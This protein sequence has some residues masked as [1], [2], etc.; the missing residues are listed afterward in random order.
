MTS[1]P[2]VETRQQARAGDFVFAPRAAGSFGRGAMPLGMI[3]DE[4]PSGI[5]IVKPYRAN[6]LNY[7][8]D[9]VT[10]T[11]SLQL[12]CASASID[13]GQVRSTR[14][15]NGQAL[16]GFTED[17]GGA[18]EVG[19]CTSDFLQVIALDPVRRDQFLRDPA[20][21]GT[22]VQQPVITDQATQVPSAQRQPF[23]GVSLRGCPGLVLLVSKT[24]DQGMLATPDGAAPLYSLL[25]MASFKRD[26]FDKYNQFGVIPLALRVSARFSSLNLEDITDW[27]FRD[28]AAISS[29]TPFQL[30]PPGDPRLV[31]PA[32][33]RAPG[34]KDAPGGFGQAP[35]DAFSAIASVVSTGEV[36]REPYAG[37]ALPL[38]ISG[39]TTVQNAIAG[40]TDLGA[41]VKLLE[42]IEKRR[43]AEVAGEQVERQVVYGRLVPF[44]VT[45]GRPVTA[46]ELK[47][48]DP[49]RLR[50][51][52]DDLRKISDKNVLED[53]TG[54]VIPD[55]R[56]RL[57]PELVID[58]ELAQG[59]PNRTDRDRIII[60]DK[61]KKKT[62]EEEEEEEDK[63][64]DKDDDKDDKDDK[65]R[66]PKGP[67]DQAGDKNKKG[68]G[69][70]QQRSPSGG[71]VEA[72]R[73]AGGGTIPP[74]G[75]GPVSL[76]GLVGGVVGL[77][78]LAPAPRGI[79]VEAG[80][81]PEAFPDFG[82]GKSACPK[83]PK[84]SSG[85]M[86]LAG[87][88][89]ADD[90]IEVADDL[91]LGEEVLI[92]ETE[93]A[94][95]INQ[96]TPELA[97][98]LSRNRPDKKCPAVDD[99]APKPIDELDQIDPETGKPIDGSAAESALPFGIP[100]GE[101]VAASYEPGT[102]TYRGLGET[103]GV[104]YELGGWQGDERTA[105][106]KDSKGRYTGIEVP[107]PG[108]K[109]QPSA[110]ASLLNMLKPEGTRTTP[111]QGEMGAPASLRGH[112]D[113]V[114]REVQEVRDIVDAAF[115]GD[116]HS[117]YAGNVVVLHTN[118]PLDDAG[119]GQGVAENYIGNHYV[120]PRTEDPEDSTPA[121]LIVM[122]AVEGHRR[123]VVINRAGFRAQRNLSGSVT[124]KGD[125]AGR[126]VI[127]AEKLLT[128]GAT[129]SSPW[130][131]AWIDE[132]IPAPVALTNS[133]A[134]AQQSIAHVPVNERI[135]G[136]AYFFNRGNRP[137]FQTAAP[138]PR[139]MDL[140]AFQGFDGINVSDYAEGFTS[141][142]VDEDG[143]VIVSSEAEQ[144]RLGYP[145][146]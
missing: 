129:D 17:Y 47:D 90:S 137:F 38:G 15:T 50:P 80:V 41:F 32:L 99:R 44:D 74:T 101:V 85:G 124:V 134:L 136:A 140:A 25:T 135:P 72:N 92:S 120:D 96:D 23:F 24:I 106:L 97:E 105:V 98:G 123:S 138:N 9:D 116:R 40:P 115:V 95:I 93:L 39:I 55:S 122:Q 103:F 143:N 52:T 2:E 111:L 68:G 82:G 6:Q 88:P 64:G 125:G 100:L 73:Q 37:T 28:R 112:L 67:G 144:A 62:E 145:S 127:A 14:I 69:S 139:I 66:P 65:D 1:I 22:Q 56:I 8:P 53:D 114:Q 128:D 57:V 132:L 20:E 121:G 119:D 113:A 58:L 70:V 43:Q 77:V 42:K 27:N 133:G 118:Q 76:A 46:L 5:L 86:G 60:R 75:E 94:E 78:P 89:V 110:M 13:P 61:K 21:P 59:S 45:E 79:A 71:N 49:S 54:R 18:I 29:A 81:V 36:P 31:D 91:D 117:S 26:T 146:F 48:K 142:N 10:N 84:D 102:K 109:V 131:G 104:D 16:D 130:F 108:D 87:D 4:T 83:P 12:L 11:M 19:G 3:V 107:A 34:D 33:V 7:E 63:E 35:G 51:R 30:Q 141:W 126:P